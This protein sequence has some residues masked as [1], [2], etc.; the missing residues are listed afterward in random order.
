[1]AEAGLSTLQRRIIGALQVDGRA[2]WRK[3][4]QV[5]DEHE[6]TVARQGAELLAAGI[7]TVAAIR[8][9]ESAVIMRLTCNPGTARLA[10]ESM[11]QRPDTSFSY[12]VTGVG[13]VV[14]EVVYEGNALNEI[15][16]LQLPSTPG[17]TS[18]ATYPVLKYFRTIRGW[19]VGVLTAAEELAMGTELTKDDT[20][21]QGVREQSLRLTENDELIAQA[22][23]R[24]G[25][26]SVEAIAR[27]VR[28]SES[29]VSRRIDWL[30]RNSHLA[31]RTL[32]E[33]EALG[34]RTEALLWIHTAPNNVEAL[35]TALAKRPEVR[36]AAAVAGDCQ[37]VVDVT[38]ANPAQLYQFL[39][40]ASWSKSMT[41]MQTTM[42]MQARKRGGQLL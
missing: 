38:V 15:L 13:D 23:Q 10:C 8:T 32:V 41:N 35:G 4:A 21:Q 40:D 17:L 11:A 22:L 5:L 29:T 6:R 14:A 30:I 27:Q 18:C 20:R 2:T 31:I 36:Y 19:R 7:I 39:A 25:R 37:L 26:A 16:N 12:L 33:P 42:V 3:I 1:M 28:L 34:L 9:R 24:D